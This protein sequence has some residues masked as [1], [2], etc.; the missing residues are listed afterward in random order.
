MRN[1]F[2]FLKN[3]LENLVKQTKNWVGI[4][5]AILIGLYQ[6]VIELSD[7]TCLVCIACEQFLQDLLSDSQGGLLLLVT[8]FVRHLIFTDSVFNQRRWNNI[9][10]AA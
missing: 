1:N 9:E 4:Y 3:H 6:I 5:Q 8:M 10:H 7:E 2:F